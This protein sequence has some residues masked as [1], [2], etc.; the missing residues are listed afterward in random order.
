HASRLIPASIGPLK[1]LQALGA[2]VA[3][4]TVWND[5][6]CYLIHARPDA[7][8]ATTIGAHETFPI[9]D[10]VIGAVIERGK[11]VIRW[12]RADRGEIAW[13]AAVGTPPV[14]AIAAVF[15]ENHP[16]ANDPATREL[17]IRCATQI[18]TDITSAP[19]KT[20][21]KKETVS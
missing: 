7:D 16:A 18:E 9:R 3:L 17:I 11:R 14:A 8:L 1:A 12:D 19:E 2:T 5:V 4:G 6:V 15:P 21:R 10:S 13:A 20:R